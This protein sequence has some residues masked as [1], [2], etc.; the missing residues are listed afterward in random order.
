ML[1]ASFLRRPLMDDVDAVHAQISRNMLTSG[2]WVTVASGWRRLP[3][4]SASGLLAD[5]G[6]LQNLR[7]SRLGSANSHCSCPPLVWLG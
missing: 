3:R 6:F 2:D 7:G 1:V 5:R 4:E